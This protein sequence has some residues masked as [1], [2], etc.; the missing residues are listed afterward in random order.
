MAGIRE[1]IKNSWNAF[2]GRDPTNDL[3]Y[4]WGWGYPYI[5][6]TR[7]DKNV[8]SV[9]NLK[10]ITSNIY[11]KIAVDTSLL[12]IKH[13]RLDKDDQYAETINDELNYILCNSANIDQTSTAFMRDI[14]LTM[15]DEGCAAV[16]PVE[17]DKDPYTSDS[18]KVLAARVGKILEWA[19]YSVL[20]ELYN[21]RK[22]IK[23]QIWVDKRICAIIE[24]PFYVIMNEQN[25]IAQRLFRVINQLEKNNAQVSSGK[26]DLL[27]QLPYAVKSEARTKIANE[28]V[29]NLEVQLTGSQYG[30][31]YIDASERV[32]QL[33]RSVENNLWTQVQDLTV[34]L[35]NVFGLSQAVFNGTANE[36]EINN[37]Y[38]SSIEPTITAIC[39]EI[40]RKW[41]TRTAI[42][43]KQAVRFFRSPFKLVP[44]SQAAEIADKF[45][46]NEIMTSNEVRSIFGLK[47]SSD[48]KANELRNSNISHPDEEEN[49]NNITNISSITKDNKKSID[50]IK[51]ML[52]N[53]F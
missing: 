52:E 30:I 45:T 50:S 51:R 48:P 28:R 5:S 1:R 49:R 34:Q 20:V 2:M 18:Y 41:L 10:N 15:F 31:G 33:N 35:Y 37:Y 7:P 21:E 22:G 8:I 11:N 3:S 16:V 46:R 39:E 25:S 14:I 32:I 40:E 42:S 47:P 12:D 6:S 17:T 38:N 29:K 53:K 44:A 24:N 4:R 19:P 43:Q 13:V 27:V 23:E 36:T 26:I 9:K